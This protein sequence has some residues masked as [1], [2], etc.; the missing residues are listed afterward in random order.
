MQEALCN[1]GTLQLLTFLTVA[2]GVKPIRIH[3]PEE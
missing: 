2:A 1:Y 3:K